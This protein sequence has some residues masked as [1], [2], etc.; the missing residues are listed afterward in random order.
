MNP[1]YPTLSLE[2]GLSLWTNLFK[3]L[4]LINLFSFF[5]K[6]VKADV[7]TVNCGMA[8]GQAAMLLSLGTKGYRAVQPNSSSMNHI[9]ANFWRKK[10]LDCFLWL[11]G[12]SGKCFLQEPVLSIWFMS[13]FEEW[14]MNY[15][16]I[17][18][19]LYLLS[20]HITLFDQMAT[21]MLAKKYFLE[22]QF[23]KF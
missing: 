18:F 17:I 4:L 3:L 10:V 12:T 20:S 8:F 13:I 7:Y 15:W 9:Y 11:F 2:Y 14:T 22:D 19:Q 21:N 5:L 6:Y 23:I 1:A 16:F